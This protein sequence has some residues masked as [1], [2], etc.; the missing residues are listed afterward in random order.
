MLFSCYHALPLPV[1]LPVSCHRLL[2]LWD[3]CPRRRVWAV[4]IK[5]REPQLR[6][7]LVGE[8]VEFV[9]DIADQPPIM[10]KPFDQGPGLACGIRKISDGQFEALVRSLG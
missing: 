6:G 4:G 10:L 9:R 7:T 1:A 8:E 2:A 5:C 3:D